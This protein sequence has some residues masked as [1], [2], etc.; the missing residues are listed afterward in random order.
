[1]IGQSICLALN[2]DSC[3]RLEGFFNWCFYFHSTLS[4]S[5]I[6]RSCFWTII[7]KE[8]IDKTLAGVFL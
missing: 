8:F 6:M 2:L 5:T 3:F 7:K 4:C 1:M